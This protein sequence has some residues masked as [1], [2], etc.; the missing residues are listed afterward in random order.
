MKIA[1]NILAVAITSLFI[2]REDVIGN[3]TYQTAHY[4]ESI[5]LKDNNK[6]IYFSKQEFLNSEIEGNYNIQGDSLVLDS[7]PQRDKII[8]KEFNKGSQ[9]NCTIE[10][11][12]K[13]GQ[14]INY[15]INLIL[16]D[17]SEI[18]LIDQFE[19]SK[20]K[21]QKIKGFYIV[22][23]K[24]LKSPLY[25]KKGEFTNYFKVEFEQKRIFENEVWHIHLNQ[26]RPRGLNGEFQEYFLR[27]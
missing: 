22:D 11:T 27:K 10:V 6:F 24:G 19:K 4:Y 8:V 13:M 5:E 9:S 14:A 7:N 20:V 2:N 12:N 26:I 25:Y 21:N 3:Y 16:V 18:E 23:T 15:K 17:G 1:L